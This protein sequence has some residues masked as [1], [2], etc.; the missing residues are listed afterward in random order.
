NLANNK[1]SG[2]I[3]YSIALMYNMNYMNLSRNVIAQNIRDISNN[4]TS[5]TTLDLSNNNLTGDLPNSLSSLSN[6][7]TLPIN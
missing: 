2:N 3:P 4:L 5:L 1:L 6:I 7:S